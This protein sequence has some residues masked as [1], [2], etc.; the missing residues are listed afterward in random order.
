MSLSA[1]CSLP[2]LDIVPRFVRIASTYASSSGGRRGGNGAFFG[3]RLWSVASPSAFLE[4]RSCSNE[5]KKGRLGGGL[6]KIQDYSGGTMWWMT[7]P[8]RDFFALW[9]KRLRKS[10]S[11]SYK[12]SS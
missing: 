11:S 9:N 10:S 12:R 6:H 7:Y 4:S 2:D 3:L 5:G 8:S 1:T